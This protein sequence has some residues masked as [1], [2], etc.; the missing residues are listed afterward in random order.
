MQKSAE[1]FIIFCTV[2][3]LEDSQK[4]VAITFGM[5]ACT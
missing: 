4:N 3:G 5:Y 2:K 1:L